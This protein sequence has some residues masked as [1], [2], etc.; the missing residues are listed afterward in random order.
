MDQSILCPSITYHPSIHSAITYPFIHHPSGTHWEYAGQRTPAKM[1]TIKVGRPE[2]LQLP[3]VYHP[4]QASVGNSDEQVDEVKSSALG[5]STG[6]PNPDSW[7]WKAVLSPNNTG[8]STM[9]PFIKIYNMHAYLKIFCNFCESL[10]LYLYGYTCLVSHLN[11]LDRS[12]LGYF[13]IIGNQHKLKQKHK[14]IPFPQIFLKP[15]RTT[16]TKT[17]LHWG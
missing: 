15:L 1:Y 5:G 2:S 6:A 17:N 10:S 16:P 11:N 8:T 7:V 13:Q 14:T 4:T 3:R 9:T 12:T